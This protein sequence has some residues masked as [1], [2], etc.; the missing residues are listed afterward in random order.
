MSKKKD[1]N[2]VIRE[3]PNGFIIAIRQLVPYYADFVEDAVP[4]KAY[5]K[6]VV[7]LAAGDVVELD[8]KPPTIP[9]DETNER[10]YSLW[11]R[12][13][14]IDEHNKNINDSIRPRHKR[15]MLLSL[16]IDV[17]DGPESVNDSEWVHA[18]E[19]AYV[20]VG[21][22]I[23]KHPGARKLAFLKARVLTDIFIAQSILDECIYKEV[24]YQGISAA[25]GR[26]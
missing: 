20:D 15:D 3:L 16:C 4:L 13:H 7:T 22:K 8:Y 14:A 6:R 18:V 26:F 25:L 2:V 24:S 11:V 12:W 5:P 9:P 17:V 23:P 21:Y 19:A 1:P 10:E